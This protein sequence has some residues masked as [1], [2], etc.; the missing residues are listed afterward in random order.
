[1]ATLAKLWSD[2]LG[3][4]DD[5]VETGMG[6]PPRFLQGRVLAQG[7]PAGQV[8]QIVDCPSGLA[9][10]PPPDLPGAPRARRSAVGASPS[11]CA[12]PVV[13]DVPKQLGPARIDLPNGVPDG[14]H[15]HRRTGNR[16]TGTHTD[17]R[18]LEV[19]GG[20]GRPRRDAD[21]GG[22]YG[23]GTDGSPRQPVGRR[24]AVVARWSPSTMSMACTVRYAA[25]KG[26]FD[27]NVLAARPRRARS[28]P[29]SRR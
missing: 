22:G 16:P 8:E 19:E 13:S 17:T 9:S 26:V 12:I 7:A 10:C 27:H 15:G 18:P 5:V 11:L 1:M 28:R 21:V 2:F 3:G 29:T 6:V 20:A 4:V 23:V 25:D 24:Q 14:A